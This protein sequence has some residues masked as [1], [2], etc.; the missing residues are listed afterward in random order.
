[1]RRVLVVA[2]G[3]GVVAAAAGGA[4]AQPAPAERPV[5]EL[6]A[7]GEQLA[8]SGKIA[9]SLPLFREAAQREPSAH[10]ECLVALTFFRL[11]RPPEA[12]L[13]LDRA[14]TAGGERPDWCGAGML[15]GDVDRA[16]ADGAFAPVAIAIVPAADVVISALSPGEVVAAPATVWL[17]W[18][19]HRVTA[20]TRQVEVVVSGKDT[21][22]LKIEP[23]VPSATE[24]RRPLGPTEVPVKG[25]RKSKLGWVV[26]GAGVAALGAG[27]GFHVAASSSRSNAMELYA[28]AAFDAERDRFATR[29]TIAISCYVTGAVVSAFGAWLVS[30]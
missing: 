21:I 10:H 6:V 9:E 24:P 1:M 17:P 25:P 28:G 14:A 2:V 27:A 16:L 7:E 29:R 8:Q 3:W 12:R 4:R 30:R 20:G 23:V 11:G 26:L 15:G 5:A 13:R 19:T 18:G 22:P